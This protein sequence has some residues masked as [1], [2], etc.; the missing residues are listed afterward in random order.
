MNCWAFIRR[1]KCVSPQPCPESTYCQYRFR[2]IMFSSVFRLVNKMKMTWFNIRH[3]SHDVILINAYWSITYLLQ[4]Y[5]CT[6]E[7]PNEVV[8]EK[9]LVPHSDQCGRY[10]RQL[11]CSTD[12]NVDSTLAWHPH[13]NGPVSGNGDQAGD[14]RPLV[15]AAGIYG[16]N[17]ELHPTEYVG[18]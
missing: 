18:M 5:L 1:F 13:S 11:P 4:L 14:M 16:L 12:N 7:L 10:Y 9:N 15:L 17:K 2:Y 6:H 8:I 3:I